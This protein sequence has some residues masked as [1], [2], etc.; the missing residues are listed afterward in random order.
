MSNEWCMTSI[1]QNC[2]TFNESKMIVTENGFDKGKF[3]VTY[4]QISDS[5]IVVKI[6]G[7]GIENHLRMK[8]IDTLYFSQGDENKMLGKFIR[9]QK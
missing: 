8:S 7:E 3:N 1:N 4:N 5:L 2:A 6:I 9:V